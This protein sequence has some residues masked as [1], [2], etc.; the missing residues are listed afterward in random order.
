MKKLILILTALILT[1][2]AATT[3]LKDGIKDS[4]GNLGNNPCYDKETNTV[5]VGCKKD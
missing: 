4:I 5:K 2:C 3:G 1:S